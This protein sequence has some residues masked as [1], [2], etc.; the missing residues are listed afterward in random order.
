[1]GEHVFYRKKRTSKRRLVAYRQRDSALEIRFK[2][3]VAGCYELELLLA[4]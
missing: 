2:P 4:L 3:A 1:M